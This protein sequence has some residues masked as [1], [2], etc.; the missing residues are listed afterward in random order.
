MVP[1]IFDDN[2]IYIPVSSSAGALRWFILDTGV[3]DAG[4]LASEECDSPLVV[5]PLTDCDAQIAKSW[6][7]YVL[8]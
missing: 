7:K 4:N 1:F 8:D 3:W 5:P 2:R 6:A